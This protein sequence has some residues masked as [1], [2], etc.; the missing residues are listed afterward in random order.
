MEE[1]DNILR[2]LETYLKAVRKFKQEMKELGI[3][4]RVIASLGTFISVVEEEAEP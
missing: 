1:E 4:V 2:R 3:E